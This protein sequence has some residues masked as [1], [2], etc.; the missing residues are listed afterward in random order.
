[1]KIEIRTPSYYS[2]YHNIDEE[3]MEMTRVISEYME[4]RSY[5]EIIN[6]I[7]IVPVVAPEDVLKNGLWKEDV[8]LSKSIGRIS[9][10][11]HIDYLKYMNGSVEKRKKL[12]VKCILDAVKLIKSKP[13][14][15]FDVKQFGM[16][17]LELLDYE[18]AEIEEI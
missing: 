2:K 1:M 12:T 10:F 11:K 9:V 14:T 18:Q 13:I 6:V 15:K 17:L 3:I 5:S 16:D 8:M 4:D 7:D